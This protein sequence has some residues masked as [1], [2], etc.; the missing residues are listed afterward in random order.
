MAS[1]PARCE[2]RTFVRPAEAA[3]ATTCRDNWKAETAATFFGTVRKVNA[4]FALESSGLT[5]SGRR[6]PTL[7][8]N[9]CAIP[10]GN[11]PA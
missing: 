2:Q 6:R 1:S 3:G 11:A 10:V 4:D 8:P 9:D 5:P 7:A